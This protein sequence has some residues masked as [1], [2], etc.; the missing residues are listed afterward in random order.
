MCEDGSARER[1]AEQGIIATAEA[2]SKF[3]IGWE[4]EWRSMYQ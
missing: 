1:R 2:C 4:P 3:K